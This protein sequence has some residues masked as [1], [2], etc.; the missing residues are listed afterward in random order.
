MDAAEAALKKLDGLTGK[1]LSDEVTNLAYSVYQNLGSEDEDEKA[2]AVKIGK[3]LVALLTP[4]TEFM[5]IEVQV[6]TFAE[7]YINAFKGKLA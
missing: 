5:K 3:G 2:M 6:R 7:Y 1:D 4:G